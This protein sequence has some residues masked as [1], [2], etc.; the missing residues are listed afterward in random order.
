MNNNRT[1]FSDVIKTPSRRNSRYDEAKEDV[2]IPTATQSSKRIGANVGPAFNDDEIPI[3][4][5]K[6]ILE[7]VTSRREDPDQV[8]IDKQDDRLAKLE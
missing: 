4:E 8:N 6:L 1:I 2:R 5:R 3:T 7:K